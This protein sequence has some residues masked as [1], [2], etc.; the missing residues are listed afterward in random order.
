MGQH[1]CPKINEADGILSASLFKSGPFVHTLALRGQTPCG[2]MHM[3]E[4]DRLLIDRLILTLERMNLKAYIDLA[5]DRRRLIV[6]SLLGG[7]L[8]G[9][10]FSIGFTVL[11]AASIVLLKYLLESNLPQ[12]GGFMA[13]VIH[14]IEER[15]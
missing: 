8:R 10:G 1:L 11:G 9:F 3:K 13:E 5:T 7:M 4:R 12:F 15:M 2:G 14:A 6:S